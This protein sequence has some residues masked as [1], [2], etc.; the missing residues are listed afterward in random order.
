VSAT[1]L[2]GANRLASNSL[3]EAMV[4]GAHAG[5]GAAREAAGMNDSFHALSLENPRAAPPRQV[6]DLA[7]IRNALKA[8]MWRS[9][10]VRR[11]ADG[12][13]EAQENIDH[14]SRYAMAQQF[15]NP[16]G[17]ELQNMLCV[18]WLMIRAALDRQETRGCHVRTDFPQ[19]DDTAWNRHVTF[20][21]E[22]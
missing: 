15:P 13:R 20:R 17:W 14:W 2:H 4:Y 11:D 12:L 9:V 3:I 22:G 21:R 8:Q 6:L 10:S 7:D 16:F 5:E 1:G 19:R 18:A